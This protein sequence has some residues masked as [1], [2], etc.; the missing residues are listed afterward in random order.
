MFEEGQERHFRATQAMSLV[1]PRNGSP[2]GHGR[3]RSVPS[4]ALFWGRNNSGN[5]RI[6][7]RT[8]ISVT[9]ITIGAWWWA[10]I[11][12]NGLPCTMT[13]L[14]TSRRKAGTNLSLSGKT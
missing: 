5:L 11:A 13:V 4:F 9:P 3:W 14:P 2:R 12:G 10:V 6:Y 7:R 8:L 1:P